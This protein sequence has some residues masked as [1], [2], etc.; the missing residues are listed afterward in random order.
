[1][2]Q[3]KFVWVKLVILHFS[4]FQLVDTV[5]HIYNKRSIKCPVK[6][7]EKPLTV[8]YKRRTSNTLLKINFKILFFPTIFIFQRLGSSG[9]KVSSKLR[10]CY[11]IFE[12]CVCFKPTFIN[13]L[14]LT[15]LSSNPAS[16]DLSQ[17][18]FRGHEKQLTYLGGGER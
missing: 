14:A 15:S 8:V 1:M 2:M 4:Y 16:Y 3:K 5:A 13:T 6:L 17:S 7:K 18:I 10:K 12:G 9:R 11:G